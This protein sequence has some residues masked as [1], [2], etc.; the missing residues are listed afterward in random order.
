MPVLQQDVFGAEASVAQQ[1]FWW[2]Y[3]PENFKTEKNRAGQGSCHR[4]SYGDT[5]NCHDEAAATKHAARGTNP[6]PRTNKK[7][8]KIGVPTPSA[9][10][11][12]LMAESGRVPVPMY[13]SASAQKSSSSSASSATS[14]SSASSA[15][16][17]PSSYQPT[18]SISS[19]GRGPRKRPSKPKRKLSEHKK[20][21]TP[22][23]SSAK[24]NELDSEIFV[25]QDVA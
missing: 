16:S 11:K 25:A 15:S 4:Q 23:K 12:E 9:I 13:Q 3:R 2:A 21:S 24:S 6:N 5:Q 8:K 18:S 19:K 22:K 20:T 14:A 10:Y 1:I 7:K 17:V